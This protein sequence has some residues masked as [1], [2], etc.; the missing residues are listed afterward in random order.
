[1]LFVEKKQQ[2]MIDSEIRMRELRCR[3]IHGTPGLLAA[4]QIATKCDFAIR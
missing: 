2:N 1:M 4:A 3:F